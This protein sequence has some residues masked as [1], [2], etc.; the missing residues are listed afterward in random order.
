MIIYNN[1]KPITPYLSETATACR[2]QWPAM[3]AASV[4]NVRA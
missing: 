3:G 1:R 4:M 2:S